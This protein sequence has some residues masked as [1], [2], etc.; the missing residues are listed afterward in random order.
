[1]G[2]LRVADH[3]TPWAM[4]PNFTLIRMTGSGDSYT[5]AVRAR[6]PDG[7]DWYIVSMIELKDGLMSHAT[8]FFA[9]VFEAPDWRR[10]FA[11]PGAG[12]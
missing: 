3:E 7:T 12:T 1:M 5:A 9:P 8:M 10:P 6:Y 4:A 11:E 2:S